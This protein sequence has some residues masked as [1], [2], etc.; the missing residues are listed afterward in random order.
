M[1]DVLFQECRFPRGMLFLGALELRNV[2]FRDTRSGGEM[3]FEESVLLDRVRF[4]GR[5]P[6]SIENSSP[7]ELAGSPDYSDVEWALDI[8]DYF[9]EVAVFGPPLA[10]IRCDPERHVKLRAASLISVDWEAFGV[11]PLTYWRIA[12]KRASIVPAEGTVAMIPSL[13]D[14]ED[15]EA[16]DQLKRLRDAGIVE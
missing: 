11:P 7:T 6:D 5:F 2:E 15:A 16:R 9:G 4:S 8:T 12:A 14:R 3:A 10:K 1:E 13:N